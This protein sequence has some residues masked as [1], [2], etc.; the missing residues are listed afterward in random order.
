MEFPN[1]LSAPDPLSVPVG[2]GLQHSPNITLP[3]M[4]G[5]RYV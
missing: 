2:E 5:K 1:S 3:V 4:N